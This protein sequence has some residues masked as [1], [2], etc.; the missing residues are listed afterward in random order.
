MAVTRRADSSSAGRRFDHGYLYRDWFL[1]IT[2]VAA[3][4][5]TGLLLLLVVLPA[6][7]FA[8]FV[9]A[10]WAPLVGVTLTAAGTPFIWN[11]YSRHHYKRDP[12]HSSQ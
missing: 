6:V 3:L 12:S 7:I 4:V 8:M 9:S 1:L 2:P 5:T 11:V 10:G